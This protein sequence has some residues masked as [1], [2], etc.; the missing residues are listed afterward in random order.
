MLDLDNVFQNDMVVPCWKNFKITG[1]TTPET[2]IKGSICSQY[3]EN[4]SDN[5]GHFVINFDPV[6]KATDDTIKISNDNKIIEINVHFGYTYLFSGQSNIEFRLKDSASYQETL[7]NFPDLNAYYYE[8]PQ[9]EYQYSDGETKPKDLVG[10]SWRKITRENCGDMSAIAFYAIE[11][12]QENSNEVPVG[13]VDCYKGGTS[14]SSW[15]PYCE[16]KS[17]ISLKKAFINP[18]VTSTKDKDEKYFIEQKKK[19]DAS[20]ELHNTRLNEFINHNP[21]KSLSEAKNAVGHTPW[22]PPMEPT[23]F[24]RPGGLYETMMKKISNYTFNQWIWYQGENDA[25]NPELY[26][27]LLYRLITIWRK[28]LHDFSLPVKVIQL[29]KYADEPKDSWAKIRQAQLKIAN[30]IPCVD[31]VSII[32]TGDKHNIHPTDKRT[33]GYRLAK[34]LIEEKYS[35]TPIPSVLEWSTNKLVLRI[36]KCNVINLK[37][38]AEFSYFYK[39]KLKKITPEIKGNLLIFNQKIEELYYQYENYTNPSVFNEDGM[40]LAAFKIIRGEKY[41][42]LRID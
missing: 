9:L 10:G 15:I 25:E 40:P 42:G 34:F 21:D 41:Y 26:T 4:I 33:V 24:L 7:D 39:D 32:D 13:I 16:L 3:K 29:P 19:Y 11:K 35:G 31:L 17:S 12:M 14:A 20:V 28:N 5:S 2:K 38:K 8:V 1:I 37:G 27:E 18:F 22:P 30:S 6:F 23:S 36:R